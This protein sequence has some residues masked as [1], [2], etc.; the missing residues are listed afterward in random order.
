MESIT[1]ITNRPEQMKER[2]SESEDKLRNY[3]RRRRG[4]YVL[5]KL[6]HSDS[7]KGKK[8]SNHDNI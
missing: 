1:N 7:N 5:E 4:K 8:P 2:I 3:D 6:L